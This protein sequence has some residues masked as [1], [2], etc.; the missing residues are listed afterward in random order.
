MPLARIVT[1][2]PEF[3]ATLSEQ[4]RTQGFTVEIVG[5]GESFQASADLEIEF[6][7]SNEQQ[8]LRK[9]T[10]LAS[11]L[12]SEIIVFPGA[13]ANRAVQPARRVNPVVEAVPLPPVASLPATPFTEV[14]EQPALLQSVEERPAVLPFPSSPTQNSTAPVA[15]ELSPSASRESGLLGGVGSDVRQSLQQTGSAFSEARN[16]L[17]E[18]LGRTS[19]KLRDSLSYLRE[20]ASSSGASVTGRAQQ[21]RERLRQ[22]AAELQA[23]RERRLA[24]LESERA[25]AQEKAAALEHHRRMQ[26]KLDEAMQQ[27]LLER[28]RIEREEQQAEQERH[29]IAAMEHAAALELRRQKEQPPAQAQPV[30]ERAPVELPVEQPP[31]RMRAMPTRRKRWA[32][33]GVLTGA[34]AISS[35]YL[36]GLTLANF[37]PRSPLPSDLTRPSV[38]QEVPFGAATVH[39]A[40][41][42]IS[43]SRPQPPQ[44]RANKTAAP[45]TAVPKPNPER[46]HLVSRPNRSESNVTADDVVVKHFGAQPK[47]AKTPVQQVKLKRYSDM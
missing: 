25:D 44:V 38:Q 22:R 12:H 9:A 35:L 1:Q 2:T 29:R 15:E 40:P 45:V 14:L 30:V 18:A 39:A 6:E 21:Y 37:R 17:G 32:L 23:A 31:A 36:V 16:E 43:A 34:I 3:A 5:P 24:E 13:V 28:E 4:L 46:R 11:Q 33:N 10:E 47:P 20:R 26:Q 8:A 41:S 7:V 27:E 42:P 19:R